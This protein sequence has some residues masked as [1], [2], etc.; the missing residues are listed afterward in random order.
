MVDVETPARVVS[1]KMVGQGGV[2]AAATNAICNAPTFEAS[3]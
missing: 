3:L 1:E 2:H